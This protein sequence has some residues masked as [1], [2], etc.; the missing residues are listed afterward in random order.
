MLALQAGVTV[1]TFGDLVR[2]PGT[3]M[4][5]AGAREKGA[6]IQIVYSPADAE[7]ICEVTSG[8]TS[9]VPVRWF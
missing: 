7:K 4:S 2:V 8:G 9:R 3:K 5:L 1:C 6:K